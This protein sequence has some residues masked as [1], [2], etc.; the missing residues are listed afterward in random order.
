MKT[1]KIVTLL[2]ASIL[3]FSLFTTIYAEKSQNVKSV[4]KKTDTSTSSFISKNE[5][6]F[7]PKTAD[8]IT[9]ALLITILISGA[10]IIMPMF[11]EKKKKDIT[12]K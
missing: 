11:F 9:I 5:Q 8:A 7:A 6:I 1:N 2:L 4:L 12:R 10:I 3:S